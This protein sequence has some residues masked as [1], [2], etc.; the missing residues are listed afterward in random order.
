MGRHFR[1]VSVEHR[2]VCPHCGK[3]SG[4]LEYRR[5]DCMIRRER[6]SRSVEKFKRKEWL[7]EDS[8]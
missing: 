6:L 1:G 2:F 5:C 8:E 7:N 3:R 4:R